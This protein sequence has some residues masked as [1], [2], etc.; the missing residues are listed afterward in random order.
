MLCRSAKLAY[1]KEELQ[2]IHICDS[3]TNPI[4]GSDQ[5][6]KADHLPIDTIMYARLLAYE[7]AAKAIQEPLIFIDTDMLITKPI[8]NSALSTI[9][10]NIIACNSTM[11]RQTFYLDGIGLMVREF[12]W[13]MFNIN[14]HKDSPQ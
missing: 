4:E 12:T 7:Q 1:G 10:W 2:I 8:Q 6:F 5:S 3:Q 13:H 9:V 11:E 14:A